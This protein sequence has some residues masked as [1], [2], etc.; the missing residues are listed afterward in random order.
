MCSSCNEQGQ[1]VTCVCVRVNLDRAAYERTFGHRCGGNLNDAY[2]TMPDIPTYFRGRWEKM[3]GRCLSR[4][5]PLHLAV[6]QKKYDL[7]R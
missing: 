3:C 5:V 1:L 4:I 7:V 2:V 6:M